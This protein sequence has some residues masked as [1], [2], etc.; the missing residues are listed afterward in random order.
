MT[1]EKKMPA[2]L[3][4]ADQIA[5]EIIERKKFHYS[6]KAIPSF[7]KYTIKTSASISGVL[8]IGRLSDTVRGESVARA[9][10]EN[11]N[12]ELIWVAEDMDPLRKLPKGVPNSYEEYIGM[13]VTDIPDYHGC[14]K[15]YA[16][17]NKEEYFKVLD[18]FVM[19]K[20]KK[21]SMREE[22]RK[23][24]FKD[25]IKLLLKNIENVIEIQ[26]KYR[27]NPLESGWSPWTPICENC[28]KIIT[29][30][31][32]GFDGGKVHYVCK[33]YSFE[34]MTAKGCGYEG[35][36][37]PLK[38]N[39]KL[40]W[41]S[42]WASQWAYWK[43]V[44]EGAGKEYQVPMSAWWVNGEICERILDFP[45]PV[46]I[47]YEHILIDGEKMSAS[48][49]NVIYPKAWLEVADPDLLRFFYNKRLMKTRSFSWRELPDMYD[50]YDRHMMVYFGKTEIGNEKESKHMKRLFEISQLKKPAFANQV[51]YS[52]AALIAQICKPEEGIERAVKLLKFTGHI[53]SLSEKEE[54]SL[55]KRLLLAKNWSEKYAPAELRIKLNEHAPEKIKEELNADEKNAITSLIKGLKGNIKDEDIQTQI[56]DI[57]RENSVEPK[58]FFWILYQIILSRDSGPRLG[59]FIIVIG[60]ENIIRLLEE[61]V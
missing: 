35:Y 1:E 13:P 3:F 59:P 47:F 4:W 46:P 39:G 34:T 50:D 40:M 45:M 20:M 55:K 2:D 37:D 29:P 14:H 49:G 21:F 53:K 51:P 26:N 48:K 16:E 36:D 61:I 22:Y 30:H 7:R 43:V 42:E 9:L 33:D 60:K 25:Y 17:H 18:E 58:R 57:A 12:T 54:E 41:K 5:K 32:L 23:G 38:G 24:S 31:V 6:D 44:S 15:S 8:H 27:Q 11:H 52:F 19:L 10:S 28:G 56:Y